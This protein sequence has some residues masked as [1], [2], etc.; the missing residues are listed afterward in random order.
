MKRYLLEETVQPGEHIYV[1]KRVLKKQVPLHWH[2]FIEIELVTDG[3]GE[4]WLNGQHHMLRRGSLSILRYTDFHQLKTDSEMKLLN[5][6]INDAVL[7]QE[8]FNRIAAGESLFF[9]LSEQETGRMEQLMLLCLDA[10]KEKD[11][12]YLQHLLDCFFMRVLRLLPEH[13]EDL[14]DEKPIRKALLYM[15]MHFRRNPTLTEVASVTH[16]NVSY[17][18]H[19]FHKETGMTYTQYLTFLKVNYA[20]KLLESTNLKISDIFQECGFA[21]HSNFLR[22]IREDTGTSPVQYRKQKQVHKVGG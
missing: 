17:F 6:S 11:G 16:Y 4:Y 12:V 2:D 10:Y 8:Q 13:T 5:L 9:Q 3:V 20:K 21:S 22:L 15:L 19:I 1:S 14:L 7:T 18:S